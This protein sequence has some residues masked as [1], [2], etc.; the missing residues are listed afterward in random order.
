MSSLLRQSLRH[1]LRC[2]QTW[3]V[4]YDRGRLPVVCAACR[5]AHEA[6][7]AAA[8]MRRA[9]ARSQERAAAEADILAYRVARY[10]DT[11]LANHP[12]A[13]RILAEVPYDLAAALVDALKERLWAA[14]PDDRH[15]RA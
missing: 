5:P 2:G 13:A 11:L 4:T 9:R 15:D 12:A 7:L 1:C 14:S 3:T 6:A 8:R 10:A